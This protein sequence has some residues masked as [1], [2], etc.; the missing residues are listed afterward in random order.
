V[1]RR[2]AGWKAASERIVTDEWSVTLERLLG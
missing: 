1:R 2:D